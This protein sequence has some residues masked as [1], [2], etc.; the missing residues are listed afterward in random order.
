L[1]IFVQLAYTGLLL[2][3]WRPIL[4][5]VTHLSLFIRRVLV[6][7]VDTGGKGDWDLV[8]FIDLA[9]GVFFQFLV[10]VVIM[11]FVRLLGGRCIDIR[12]PSQFAPLRKLQ[13]RLIRSFVC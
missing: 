5:V 4:K 11:F 1:S 13:Q 8:F 3:S 6:V 10:E 7:F 9:L 12:G 2:R